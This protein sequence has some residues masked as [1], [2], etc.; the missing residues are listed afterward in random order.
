TEGSAASDDLSNISP[1][2]HAPGDT[3][4]LRGQNLARVITLNETGNISL[5][6]G[7]TFVTG[8]YDNSIT[9]QLWDK[10]G[11]AQNELFW[12]EVTRSTAAVSSVAAFRTNSFPFISTEGETAVPATT[13]GTTILTANTDKRLQNITGVSALTSDYVIDT[14]TTDAVAGDYFWIKYNAQITVGAFDVTIGGV[15]PITL[16]ADQALIGG[17]IFFAYYNGT[18]WKTSAFP[19]MG[20][21]LFKLATEFINDN[22][23]TAAKVDAA[24]RTETINIIASFESNEQG[25]VKYEIPFSCNV[26]KISSAVIKDI[27]GGGN[28]GV[29][30]VKDNAA[31]VMATIN[32]TAGAAI[33]TIFSDAPTVNN[34]FVA[35]DILTFNNTKSTAGGKTLVSITLIR[36]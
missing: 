13:G 16:T 18:A 10:G 33:G 25:D 6:G 27:A 12:F 32:H 14:V 5:V 11:A 31:A 35:G 30:I 2:G 24:L 23:I 36:T 26:T 8:G 20:S 29:T 19:D 4:V 7:A 3:I 1:A 34:A 28:N 9:L 17:W 15:A 22:A 21:V